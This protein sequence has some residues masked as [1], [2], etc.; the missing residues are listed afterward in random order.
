MNIAAGF[1][2]LVLVV[3]DWG[4]DDYPWSSLAI[5]AMIAGALATP[6]AD[7][8]ASFEQSRGR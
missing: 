1:A 3:S 4:R 6:A 5:L 8:P 7:V 2:T